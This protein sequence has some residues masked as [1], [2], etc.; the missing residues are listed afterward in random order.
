[1][2]E[3]CICCGKPGKF[4]IILASGPQNQDF[5]RRDDDRFYIPNQAAREG[6]HPDMRERW[7]CSEH[8]RA[9]DDAV[10]ATI[11]YH[12]TENGLLRVNKPE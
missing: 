10:R 7:F 8:I 5:H 12:Q 11:L 1:M 6:D 3:K 4:S 2:T 9:I